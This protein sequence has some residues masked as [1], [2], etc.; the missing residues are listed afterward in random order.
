MLKPSGIMITP[1]YKL[2]SRCMTAC[3]NID[4]TNLILTKIANVHD[5][6]DSDISATESGAS[7]S[8]FEMK[9]QY[10]EAS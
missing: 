7:R 9:L 3:K 1:G 6:E 8:D 4:T 2:C 10:Q 5:F